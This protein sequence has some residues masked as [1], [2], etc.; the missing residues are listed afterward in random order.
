MY[1]APDGSDQAPGTKAAPKATLGSAVARAI[2]LKVKEVALKDGTYYMSSPVVLGP[3]ASGLYIHADVGATPI[4]KGSMKLSGL[5]WTAA[6]PTPT[7]PISGVMKTQVNATFDQ[8]FLNDKKQVLARFPKYREKAKPGDPEVFLNGSTKAADIKAQSAKWADPAG[9]ILIGM[10]NAEWGDIY[11]NIIGKGGTATNGLLVGDPIGNN[12]P[13]QGLSDNT[14][15]VENIREEVTTPGEWFL[16]KKTSTLYFYPPLATNL[17]DASIEVTQSESL[18]ELRGTQAAPVKNVRIDGLTF[19]QTLNTFMKKTEPLLRSDWM[20]YRG[21]TVFI[22]GGEDIEISNN[23]LTDVGGNAILVNGYNRRVNIH[24]NYIHDIGASAIAF[25]GKQS[26]VRSSTD[27]NAMPPDQYKDAANYT[28]LDLTPGPKTNEYPAQ[29]TAA[30]NLI[31]DIGNRDKQSTGVE[32]SMSM[33]IKVSHN[34]I[35]NT[36]RAGINIGDGTWG[37]HVLEYNDVFNT[38]LETGDHGAFNSWGRDRFWSPDR[39]AMNTFMAA[40]PDAWKLDVIKPITINN[41]RFRCDRGWDIDLDDGSS[42]YIVTNNVLLKGGL[43]F[44]EGFGRKGSNN[45]M[46]NNTFHPH[47]WFKDSLDVF[48]NNIVMRKYEPVWLVGFGK[49]IDNNF[50]T[51]KSDLDAVRAMDPNKKWDLNSI[52]GSALFVDPTKGDYSVAA[53]SPALSAA[54]GFKNIDMTQFGVQ[55]ERLKA[56]RKLPDFPAPVIPSAEY[57]PSDVTVLASM[58]VVSITTDGQK[59]SYGLPSI[60]GVLIEATIVGDIGATSGLLANDVILSAGG[61]PTNSVPDF[62]AIYDALPVGQSISLTIMRN[63]AQQSITLGPKGSEARVLSTDAGVT[64]AATSQANATVPPSFAIDKDPA[65][66]WSAAA[67]T[68]TAPTA[69]L[70]QTFSSVVQIS[71]IQLNEQHNLAKDGV[72]PINSFT[73]EAD[74]GTGTWKKI[75]EGTTI[76]EMVITLPASVKAKALR[77]TVGVVKFS[78]SLYTFWAIG[79]K[80]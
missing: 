18:I 74:D 78:P 47:V 43:K 32:I 46:L 16:D 71:A 24:A 69:T 23:V 44:R 8:L 3:A 10:V 25:V 41:N 58:Q 49:T 42:N 52:S 79:K 6:D 59:S 12:R 28:K 29:S 5:T 56:I 38:V 62:R 26:A 39:N 73:I 34:S 76:R 17:Q 67:P 20:F 66:R 33:D 9:G 48:T 1:A 50:F 54:V 68:T 7:A 13:E 40:N 63:Q 15:Y 61:K 51:S 36:P 19:K 22:E 70:M 4:L 21:G 45:I 57:V 75:K 77:I 2:E 14:Q 11:Y 55:N 37:G 31:H 27:A 72:S 65:S 30:D 64:A 80:L 53:S 35:Y 60:A